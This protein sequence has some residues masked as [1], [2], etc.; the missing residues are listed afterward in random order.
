[1]L[2]FDASENINKIYN[3]EQTNSMKVK[4][5]AI[6]NSK[7]ITQCN[8][9]QRNSATV[10]NVSANCTKVTNISAKCINYKEIRCI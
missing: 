1:M 5:K 2:E 3:I 6:R 7:L 10:L 8:I 9:C 4:I